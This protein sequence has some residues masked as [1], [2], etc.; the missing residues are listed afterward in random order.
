MATN[1][2]PP[3]YCLPTCLSRPSEG[4]DNKAIQR[5]TQNNTKGTATKKSSINRGPWGGGDLSNS[6]KTQCDW[7]NGAK[8]NRKLLRTLTQSF[9]IA[10]AIVQTPCKGWT[11]NAPLPPIPTRNSPWETF[12]PKMLQTMFIFF[13]NFSTFSETLTKIRDPSA[14]KWS[15]LERNK[16]KIYVTHQNMLHI[17]LTQN[18]EVHWRTSLV[19]STGRGE[20]L[21]PPSPPDLPH[22]S[23]YHL[24]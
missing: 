2:P 20:C 4:G 6:S 18:S 11:V 21:L 23:G 9:F 7:Y 12:L 13:C 8:L 16:T 1:H 14:S 17:Y 5:E 24:Q 19:K 22:P 15:F 10:N 3:P